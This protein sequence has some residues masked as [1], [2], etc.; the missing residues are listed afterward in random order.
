MNR[1]QAT[2]SAKVPQELKRELERR[3]AKLSD[4]IRK[5]L[6]MELRD[7]KARELE[8]VLRG[9]DLSRISEE[10]IVRDV[11]ETREER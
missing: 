5:G 4:A 6:E 10:R 9:V 3:G 8:A 11:R 2:V 7:L 1:K